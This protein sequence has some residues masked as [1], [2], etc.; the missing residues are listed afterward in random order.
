MNLLGIAIWGIGKHSRERI[1]PALAKIDNLNIIGVCSRSEAVVI[2]CANQWYCEGWTDPQK[3]L[4]NSKV[5][6]VYIASPIGVHF[7]M[8]KYPSRQ[9]AKTLSRIQAT[10]NLF[11]TH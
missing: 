4:T 1:L 8:A 5:D 6:I 7:D 9:S 2:E 10:L 3:M 11:Y